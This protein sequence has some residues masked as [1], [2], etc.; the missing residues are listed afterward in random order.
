MLFRSDGELITDVTD[1]NRLGH[2]VDAS[3]DKQIYFQPGISLIF[4]CRYYMA[5]ADHEAL[6]AAISIFDFTQTC[7][8]DVY[9]YPPSGK[10]GLG[11]ALLAEITNNDLAR[12]A[13]CKVGSY[14][15]RTQ[16]TDGSWILPD[17]EMYRMI[18]DKRHP[19]PMMDL[20]AEF[21]IF[22]W[23]IASLL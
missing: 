23:E 16:Q 13:A 6:Q 3:R 5:T 22:L 1:E 10:L 4:L 8:D 15:V 11:C 9:C 19:E 21:C 17:E 12:Q 14:L 18:T 2:Y 20:T 7:A